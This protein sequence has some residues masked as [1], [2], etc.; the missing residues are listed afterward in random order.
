MDRGFG[1]VF[2][3]TPVFPGFSLWA[4]GRVFLLFILL[5]VDPDFG[6]LSVVPYLRFYAGFSRGFCKVCAG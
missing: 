1:L 6:I 3:E 5:I 2:L 4:L